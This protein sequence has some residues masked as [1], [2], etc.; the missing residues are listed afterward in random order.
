[1]F[2]RGIIDDSYEAPSKATECLTMGL[3]E[4]SLKRS[5][6]VGD[7]IT[8]LIDNLDDL[9]ENGLAFT[10]DKQISWLCPP[11]EIDKL[12]SFEVRHRADEFLAYYFLLRLLLARHVLDIRPDSS[13]LWEDERCHGALWLLRHGSIP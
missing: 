9:Y 13:A 11:L 6:A 12:V 1:M 2:T 5:S 7:V 10:K 8:C 3:D 4:D